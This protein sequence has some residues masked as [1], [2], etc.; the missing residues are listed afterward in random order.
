ML[1]AFVSDSHDN[2]ENLRKALDE[3]LARSVDTVFHLGDIVAP[4]VYFDVLKNYTDKIRFIIIF[5]N[6]DGD[7]SMWMKIAHEDG[8]IDLQGGDFRELE[9]KGKKIFLTHYP[10]IAK[11]AA[12]SG[13][14][15]AVFYGHDHLA[16]VKFVNNKILLANPGEIAGN[17]T[18]NPSFGLWNVKS[19]DFEIVYL[20]DVA[21]NR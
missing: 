8:N 13:N 19:N 17:N 5:G 18:G 4:T 21:D 7:K 14:F 9:V 11:I 1:Y 12:L 6:N 2:Y 15:D 16:N 3:V 20:K 10:D